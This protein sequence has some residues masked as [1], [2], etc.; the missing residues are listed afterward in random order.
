MGREV[1]E[2]SRVTFAIS[3]QLEPVFSPM[4]VIVLF[5]SALVWPHLESWGLFWALQVKKDINLSQSIKR[6]ATRMAKNLQ[7][8]SYEEKLSVLPIY[9]GDLKDTDTDEKNGL[10]LILRQHK[11]KTIY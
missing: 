8:K 5:C 4:G 7:G 9:R 3:Q 6:R 2:D 11:S 1:R 10:I